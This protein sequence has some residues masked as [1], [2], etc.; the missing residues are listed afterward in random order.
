M[1][2]KPMVPPSLYLASGPIGGI[3]AFMLTIVWFFAVGLILDPGPIT[4]PLAF[5]FN[6]TSAAS[7]PVWPVIV[8]AALLSAILGVLLARKTAEETPL[9]TAIL[10]SGCLAGIVGSFEAAIWSLCLA[11]LLELSL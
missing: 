7:Q 2:T 1:N 11:I 5:L 9:P 10:L 3:I 8:P 4:R 6:P